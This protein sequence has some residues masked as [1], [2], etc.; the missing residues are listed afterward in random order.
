MTADLQI[1]LD[2]QNTIRQLREELHRE[3]EN[4]LRTLAAVVMAAGGSVTVPRQYLIA[5]D[6]SV[7]TIENTIDGGVQITA[8]R[9]SA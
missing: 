2:L 8:K 6:N 3:R 1:T 5:A 7:V 4:S 9:Q